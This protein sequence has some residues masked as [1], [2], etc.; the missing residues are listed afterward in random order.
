MAAPLTDLLESSVPCSHCLAWTVECETSF[1]M[2]KTALTL[3]PVLRHFDPTLWAAVH[4]DASQNAVDAVLLQWQPGESEPR[5]V[6]FML[7]KLAGAQYRYDARNVE[8]LAVHW[9]SPLGAQ[10]SWGWPSK[11]IRITIFSTTC[12]LRRHCLSASCDCVSSWQIIISQRSNMCRNWR[13]LF[14]ISCR[15]LGIRLRSRHP[16]TCWCSR[17]QTDCPRYIL[18]NA[19]MTHQ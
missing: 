8:A 12:S 10:S 16:F 13:M 3:A 4:I 6:A 11:F 9:R 5:P 17:P 19:A 15:V 1:G 18:Y 7:R 2:I 14:L